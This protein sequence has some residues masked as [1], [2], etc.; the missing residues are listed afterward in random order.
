MKCNNTYK[1]VVNIPTPHIAKPVSDITDAIDNNAYLER[2]GL[3]RKSRRPRHCSRQ[4]TRTFPR[5]T[6]DC[7][8]S[9]VN[10]QR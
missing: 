7:V 10:L 6:P 9:A 2:K 4:H 8:E 3:R 1:R 5:P